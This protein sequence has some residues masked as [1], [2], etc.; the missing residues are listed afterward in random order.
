MFLLHSLER[1]H[2]AI[3]LE[4]T[5]IINNGVARTLLSTSHE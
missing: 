5:T 2:T 4:L 3:A 1:A